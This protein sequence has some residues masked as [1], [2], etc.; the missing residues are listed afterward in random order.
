MDAYL[1]K[2]RICIVTSCILRSNKKIPTGKVEGTVLNNQV[3]HY[4]IS[5]AVHEH[6]ALVMRIKNILV[7]NRLLRYDRT[8]LR[9]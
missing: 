7:F 8:L 9:F 4:H 6:I 3:R 5:F 1:R 2:I